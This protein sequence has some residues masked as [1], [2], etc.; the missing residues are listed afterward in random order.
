MPAQASGCR[1]EPTYGFQARAQARTKALPGGLP[2]GRPPPTRLV[3]YRRA[4]GWR[5]AT[6][7]SGPAGHVPRSRPLPCAF[8]AGASAR[9]SRAIS[10]KTSSLGWGTRRT[11]GHH[12]ADTPYLTVSHSQPSPPRVH[13]TA[14]ALCP[15]TAA[16]RADPPHGGEE[17]SRARASSGPDA[18]LRHWR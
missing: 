16:E 9:V 17:S 11:R 6:E 8:M 12:G 1:L 7:H 18:C 4:A 3:A 10:R 5:A 13:A 15:P 2:Q 14:G